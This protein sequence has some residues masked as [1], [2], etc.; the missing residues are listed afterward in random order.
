MVCEDCAGR[1]YA[2]ST[3]EVEYNG[4]SIGDIMD[5]SIDEAA[6]FFAGVPKIARTST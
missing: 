6:E 1:R 3:L 5:L 2:A 4:K